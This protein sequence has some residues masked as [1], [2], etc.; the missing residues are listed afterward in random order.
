IQRLAGILRSQSAEVRQG[1]ACQA[2][3]TDRGTD[4]V[5]LHDARQTLPKHPSPSGPQTL[6]PAHFHPGQTAVGRPCCAVRH[7]LETVQV[8]WES[9]FYRRLSTSVARRELR[10]PRCPTATDP[11]RPISHRLASLLLNAVCCRQH[12]PCAC[13]KI[14]RFARGAPPSPITCR[15]TRPCRISRAVASSAGRSIA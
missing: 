5:V 11:E 1:S 6:R 12:H 4:F 15:P 2:R 8:T 14:E 7:R 3:Y 10:L 9:S 13:V